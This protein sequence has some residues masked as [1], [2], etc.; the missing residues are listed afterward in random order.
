MSSIKNCVAQIMG[1]GHTWEEAVAIFRGTSI[2]P[3]DVLP[4][5]AALVPACTSPCVPLAPQPVP[6]T[7]SP[8]D[9]QP[10]GNQIPRTNSFQHYHVRMGYAVEDP[11][12]C[13]WRIFRLPLFLAGPVEQSGAASGPIHLRR[14]GCLTTLNQLLAEV[15]GDQETAAPAG[16]CSLPNRPVEPTAAVCPKRIEAPFGG[17]AFDPV[18]EEIRQ[19]G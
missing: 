2:R 16:D 7:S 19:A 9:S 10:P 11:L 6:M 8:P 5:D 15:A 13:G 12:P 3:P 17:D 1:E 14:A 4:A 18:S